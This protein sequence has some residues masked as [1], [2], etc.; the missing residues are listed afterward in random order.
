MTTAL[1]L[2]GVLDGAAAVNPSRA[3]VRI[4]DNRTAP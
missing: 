2:K 3:D 1:P 4:Y